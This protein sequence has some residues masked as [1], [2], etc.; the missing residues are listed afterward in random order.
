MVHTREA[1]E[2]TIPPRTWIIHRRD[3]RYHQQRRKGCRTYRGQDRRDI[4]GDKRY[5]G[6]REPSAR[7]ADHRRERRE[8]LFGDGDH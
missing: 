1:E 8:Y 7:G 3:N 2:D 5:G 6:A 4:G